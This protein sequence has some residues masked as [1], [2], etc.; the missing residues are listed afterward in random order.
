MPKINPKISAIA[1]V[2]PELSNL[3]KEYSNYFT[4]LLRMI[5]WE[6]KKDAISDTA[7]PSIL[8]PPFYK[9]NIKIFKAKV[10]CNNYTDSCKK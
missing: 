5:S 10:C 8:I 7:R 4:S 1:T 6:T 9:N 3:S 2:I